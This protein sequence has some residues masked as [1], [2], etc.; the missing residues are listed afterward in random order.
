GEKYADQVGPQ[1]GKDG[2]GIAIDEEDQRVFVAN[3]DFRLNPPGEELVP[4]A[5]TES[6]RIVEAEP[7]VYETA[8]FLDSVMPN[9]VGGDHTAALPAGVAYHQGRDVLYLGDQN[10]RKIFEIDPD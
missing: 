3:R 4:F 2:Y 7:F 10:G 5:I 9:S 1:F 6:T 8:G